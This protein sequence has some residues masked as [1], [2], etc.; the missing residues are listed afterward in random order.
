[1]QKRRAPQAQ[2]D[3]GLVEDEIQNRVCRWKKLKANGN[4]EIVLTGTRCLLSE[5]HTL[6]KVSF[7][8]IYRLD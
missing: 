1:M 4:K 8:G 2:Y 6:I 3:N 5:L 7:D